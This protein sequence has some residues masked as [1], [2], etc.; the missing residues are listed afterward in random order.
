MQE[1]KTNDN[2]QKDKYVRRRGR[3]V[4]DDT[5]GAYATSQGDGN[6]EKVVSCN[7]ASKSSQGKLSI[8]QGRQTAGNV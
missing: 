2:A 8:R 7:R 5:K 3:Y 1:K 4:K 6:K